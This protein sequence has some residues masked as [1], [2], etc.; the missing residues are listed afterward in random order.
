[1][2][3]HKG[4]HS[5]CLFRR[6]VLIGVRDAPE[7]VCKR[8]EIAR[9]VWFQVIERIKGRSKRGKLVVLGCTHAKPRTYRL[10][11]HGNSLIQS[12]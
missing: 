10:Q 6:N 12:C 9:T 3:F 5:S 11:R 1:M 2:F 8:G 4:L 7:H